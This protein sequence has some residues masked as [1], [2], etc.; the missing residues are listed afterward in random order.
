MSYKIL[1]VSTTETEARLAAFDKPGRTLTEN[2]SIAGHEIKRLVTGVGSVSTVWALKEWLYTNGSPDLIINTG[3]AGS[4]ID[5]IRPGDVVMPVTDCFADLG[6]ETGEGFFTVFESGLADPERFPFSKGVLRAEN[7]FVAKASA[8]VRPACAA[9][10]NMASGTIA[11]IE[12]IRTKFNP[13]IETMEG[14][15]FFYICAREKVPFLA[16]RAISNR[17]EIR[18]RSRWNIPLA[19]DNLETT[20]VEFI[21]S[22]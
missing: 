4:F 9:T 15:A 8:F 14:A 5:E 18:D 16:F 7:K 12:K 21:K 6:V 11:T 20:L 10:V 3:I 17:I 22:L 13:D 19:L 2:L 1:C